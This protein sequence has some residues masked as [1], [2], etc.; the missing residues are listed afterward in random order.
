ML[1]L[2]SYFMGAF[3]IPRLITHWKEDNSNEDRKNLIVSVL[4]E[5]FLLMPLMQWTSFYLFLVFIM[6]YHLISYM[7]KKIV[8]NLYV[9]RILEFIFLL[10]VGGFFLGVFSC[11]IDFNEAIQQILMNIIQVHVLF[12]IYAAVDWRNF[13]IILF[14]VLVLINE[15]NT[16][17]RFILHLIK[18]EPMLNSETTDSQELGRGKIIGVIERLLFFLFVFTNNYGSIAFILVAKGFTRFR[19]LDDKNFA[20]YVLIGTLLS[21]SLSIFWAFYIQSLVF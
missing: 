3:L 18:T 7:I 14:G 10:I 19:E 12:S 1:I 11:I 5:L 13:F 6:F 4:I 2:F 8:A 9:V 20:E 17:V 16:I 21:S 15:M